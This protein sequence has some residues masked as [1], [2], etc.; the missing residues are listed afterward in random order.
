LVE[1]GVG[2]WRV[3]WVGGVVML[4]VVVCDVLCGRAVSAASG[5]HS[6]YRRAL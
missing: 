6:A 4:L 5:Y 2:E 1:S 3:G